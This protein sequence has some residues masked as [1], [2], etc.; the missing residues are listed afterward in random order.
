MKEYNKIVRSRIPKIIEENGSTPDI[1]RVQLFTSEAKQL[2]KN[3]V[4]EEAQEVF[5]SN[6]RDELLEEIADLQEALDALK[7]SLNVAEDDIRTIRK[8]KNLTRG[9]FIAH[10]NAYNETYLIKLKTV[11]N[12][13]KEET[14]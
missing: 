11:D 9:G 1:D 6:A 5:E 3:K 13:K 7:Y 8:S 4:M 12:A 10:D 14:K 2:L